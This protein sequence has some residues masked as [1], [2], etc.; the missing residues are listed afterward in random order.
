MSIKNTEKLVKTKLD[1]SWDFLNIHSELNSTG[2]QI[3]PLGHYRF[4]LKRIMLPML[5]TCVN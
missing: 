1:L 2:K 3:T 5:I 4:M